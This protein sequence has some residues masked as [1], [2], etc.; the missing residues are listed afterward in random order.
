[1]FVSATLRRREIWCPLISM[2]MTLVNKQ[3]REGKE[4]FVKFCKNI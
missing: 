4:K 2:F 1:M 3:K